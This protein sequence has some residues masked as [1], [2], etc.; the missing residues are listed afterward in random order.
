MNLTRDILDHT[1][2][3]S[4][5]LKAR[6]Y[7]GRQPLENGATNCSFHGLTSSHGAHGKMSKKEIPG[8]YWGESRERCLLTK[9]IDSFVVKHL[10]ANECTDSEKK[11]YFQIQAN[12]TAPAG[13][14]YSQD[15]VKRRKIEE[16]VRT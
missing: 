2:P 12:H 7:I 6:S 13:S 4:F 3:V 5:C 9:S 8:F 10:V 16:E 1:V 15:A 11:K 14:R